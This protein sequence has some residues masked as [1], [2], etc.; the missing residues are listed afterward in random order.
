MV[1]IGGARQVGKTT[2]ALDHLKPSTLENPAY[3]N[4]DNA[5]TRSSIIRGELPPKQKLVVIDEVRKYARWRNLAKGFYDTYRGSIPFLITGSARLDYYRRGGD[6]LQ[7]RYHYFRLHPFSPREI[8]NNPDRGDVE[9][10]LQFGG[11]PEPCIKAD[12]RSWRRWQLERIS[13]VV[14]DD[15]RDLENVREISLMELL[16]EELPNRVGSSLSVRNLCSTLQVA[17]D[18][19]ERWISILE[20][21]YLCFRIP[22][23][24]APRIRAVKKE[25]KLYLV[26]WSRV[27]SPGERF[28]NLVACQ[29]LKFCHYVEDRDGFRMELRY[30][31]DTDK[32][33]IDFVVLKEKEPIFAVECKTGEHSVSPSIRYFRERTP[34]PRFYQIHLGTKDWGDAEKHVRVL[35]FHTFCIELEMP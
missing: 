29:L 30:V 11:F 18:T 15:I 19:A 23:Y 24:G 34:I 25:Q 20:R 32:R 28:E 33:E 17:H 3:L 16:V 21:V 4:Y 7:G 5:A 22:P 27:P 14:Y 10:L 9:H 12:V 8:N 31:R 13:R 35:P 26:D 6:S 1:F 2:F